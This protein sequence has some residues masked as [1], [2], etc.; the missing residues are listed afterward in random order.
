MSNMIKNINNNNKENDTNELFETIIF[1]QGFYNELIEDICS[2]E[3]D[4]EIQD[5]KNGKNLNK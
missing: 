2:N 1:N 5:I 4:N 3:F